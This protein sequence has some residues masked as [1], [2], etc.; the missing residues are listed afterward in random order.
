[1]KRDMELI[2]KLLL[3]LENDQLIDLTKYDEAVVAYHK[4]LL[5]ESG[6]AYGVVSDV[7]EG[8]NAVIFRL[9][10]NGH[11]FLDAARDET[12]WRSVMSRIA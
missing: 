7:A 2:R 6:L 5:V 12:G 8:L 10:W 9:T 4:A 3:T 1:M 11:E